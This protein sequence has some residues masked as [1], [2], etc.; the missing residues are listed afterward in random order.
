M[1]VTPPLLAAPVPLKHV[2]P[3]ATLTA[4]EVPPD[5]VPVV[6]PP[7]L[8]APVPVP[9]PAPD[10]APLPVLVVVLAAPE[11]VLVLVP[12]ATVEVPPPVSD[13]VAAG[14]V[15]AA[16]DGPALVLEPPCVPPPHEASSTIAQ[17]ETDSV[18][19]FMAL[20]R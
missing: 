12:V 16:D 5:V 11:F 1:G 17:S 6:V 19:R 2:V 14:D 8:V 9:V 7:P 15:L 3:T 13:E 20:I 10:L 4:V 18:A